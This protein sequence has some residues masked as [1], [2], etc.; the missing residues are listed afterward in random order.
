[1]TAVLPREAVRV[2]ILRRSLIHIT[3]KIASIVQRHNPAKLRELLERIAKGARPSPYRQADAVKEQVLSVSA[4]CRGS[5][6]CLT[7]SIAIALLC[8]IHGT[9]PTWCVGVLMTPPFTAH[10]WVEA[11]DRVV[12][13]VLLVGD[14]RTFYKVTAG[15]VR[16]S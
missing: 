4:E 5:D 1:M 14:Y 12:E 8:R 6:A 15:R 10:A 16:S 7:R 9:W 11:E 2:G 3:V 13:D